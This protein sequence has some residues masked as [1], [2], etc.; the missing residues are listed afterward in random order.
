MYLL[1]YVH[2]QEWLQ[3]IP[4]YDLHD[5]FELHNQTLAALKNTKWSIVAVP[6][7][8]TGVMIMHYISRSF[9]SF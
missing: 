7:N 2:E 4:S 6:H 1:Y 9:M 3:S 8:V 5:A